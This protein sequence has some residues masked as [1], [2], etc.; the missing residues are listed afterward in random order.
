MFW[1]A[2][3]GTAPGL[4]LITALGYTFATI[5]MKLL[6]QSTDATGITLLTLGFGAAIVAEVALLR[7]TDV[8]V[9]YITIIG[10]ET[11][12]VLLYATMIGEGFG[13]RQAVGAA[14]VLA[15]LL[16]VTS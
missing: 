5:G 3:L 4:V 2:S 13:L 11:M 1:F 10:S 6:A 15:G 7:K 16:A 12:L 14:L 9:A 8:S